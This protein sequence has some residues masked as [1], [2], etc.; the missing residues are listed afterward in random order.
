MKFQDLLIPVDE[1]RIDKIEVNQ[2]LHTLVSALSQLQGDHF[3]GH[4]E[5][6]KW[7]RMKLTG[8]RSYKMRII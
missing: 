6:N 1:Y 7:H 3:A 2:Q 5:L 8:K 4:F